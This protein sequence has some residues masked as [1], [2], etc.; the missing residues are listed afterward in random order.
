MKKRGL[1]LFLILFSLI[2]TTSFV[3]GIENCSEWDEDR[4]ACELTENCTYEDFASVC[5]AD[6]YPY[7]FTSQAECEDA[8][9]GGVCLWEE[10]WCDPIDF[11]ETW[12]GFSFCFDFDNNKTGCVLC[13]I[14][15]QEKL[16][17]CQLFT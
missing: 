11:E 5:V 12:E 3:L 10:V 7:D 13:A 15:H 9:G 2:F 4:G 1:I 14:Y 16:V 6:C 17:Y 8:F